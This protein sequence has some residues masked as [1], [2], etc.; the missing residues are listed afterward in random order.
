[1]TR[2]FGSRLRESSALG[3]AAATYSS[4]AI[5][6][7]T[8]VVMTRSMTAHDFGS[9]RYVLAAI[10]L[11]AVVAN[12]G[13]PYSAAHLLTRQRGV[14]QA[15][16]IASSTQLLGAALVVTGGLLAAFA[17]MVREHVDAAP[18]LLLTAGLMWTIAIQRHFMYALRGSG[19]SREI[20][21]QTVLPPS[22]ILCLA[23]GVALCRGG[24]E[25]GQALTITAVAYLITHLWTSTRLSLWRQRHLGPE[26]S[27]LFTAQRTTGIPIYKGALVSVGVGELVIVIGGAIVG[28][29]AFG[30]FAL[31]L[32]L[33]APV[34][35]LPTVIGM[36]QFRRFGRQN[37]LPPSMILSATAK[38]AGLGT[39]GLAVGWIAFPWIFPEQMS[40]A[41]VMFPVLAI[42]LLAHGLADYVNQFLQAKG[43]GERIKRAAYGVGVVHAGTAILSIPA[44]GAW[45][46]V[47]AKLAGSLV[48]MTSM[49]VLTTRR[50]HEGS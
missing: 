14:A 6:M 24:I 23:A 40:T 36:V 21:L 4:A 42:A 41:R 25:L 11:G 35:T 37:S 26:R 47:I 1:M 2:S 10:G 45:G 46:L 20:A 18:L 9:Y 15:R 5:A 48:Y 39:L 38:S 3:L 31:A 8:S 22:L 44:W 29:L 30:H 34:A 28:E 13:L 17:L 12:V 43:Q 16:T 27:A 49:I 32:S 33:A 7:G 19:K 50:G